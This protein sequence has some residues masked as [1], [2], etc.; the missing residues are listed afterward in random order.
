MIPQNPRRILILTRDML[1]DLVNTTGAVASLR[2]RYPSATIVLEGGR[3]AT[4]LFP[5][6][7]VWVRRRGGLLEKARRVAAF[8]RG[9]FDLAVSLDNSHEHARLCR[10]AGI[11]V[12]GSHK[13][14]PELFAASVA[15]DP[16]GHDLFGLL[17]GVLGLLGAPPEI[18]PLIPISEADHDLAR[19][20][21]PENRVCLF[22]GSSDTAKSWPA[23]RWIE[24]IHSLRD[25]FSFVVLAGP[26][27][28]ALRDEIASLGGVPAL[29]RPLSVPQLAA[30]V[31]RLSALV[32][33]DTGPA[34]IAGAL[35]V[36]VVVL[37][38]PTDPARFHP[39]G[40]NWVALREMTTCEHYGAGC[41]HLSASRVC[42]QTCMRAISAAQVTEALRGKVP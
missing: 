19:S 13:G 4:E 36:R 40:S 27:E 38:G 14:K 6:L 17:P 34:H 31:A 12:V 28:E 26:G 10:S 18:T 25:Q 15:F 29:T 39:W 9:S 21:V 42:S 23:D 37:Y 2:A 35:E 8:R 11:P 22:V 30:C 41:A 16:E 5:D 3:A 32:C 7:E 1:G 33:A 20:L 24:L